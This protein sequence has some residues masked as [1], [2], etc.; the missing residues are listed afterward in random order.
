MLDLC[1]SA[2]QEISIEQYIFS[3]HGI[4]ADLLHLLT[5]KARQG[6]RV[7]VLADAFGSKFLLTS[8]KVHALQR[9][10][11]EVLHFHGH[12]KVLRHPSRL[13]NRLHR[14]TVICD[15]RSVMTG[16]TCFLPRMSDW[17]D[18]MIRIEGAVARQAAR[19]FEETWRYSKGE[20]PYPHDP[21]NELKA[22][23]PAG[24]RY[25][26]NSPMPPNRQDYYD[27]LLKRLEQAKEKVSFITPYL[28]PVRRYRDALLPAVERGAKVRLIIPASSDHFSVDLAGRFFADSMKRAGVEIYGYEPTMVHAKLALIDEDFSAVGSFNLGVDSFKMNLEGAVVSRSKALAAALSEQIEK[29]LSQSRRL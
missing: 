8:S 29:D 27:L 9:A 25:V 14:K 15:N 17:R 5:E 16:G 3:R 21:D 24:W 19:C 13:F 1:A 11:G 18:T 6:V 23:Q 2:Q 12:R 22:D 7:R 20:T 10:G 26:V 4:G 28:L